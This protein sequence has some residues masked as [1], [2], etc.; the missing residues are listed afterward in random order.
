MRIG[1]KEAALIVYR[2]SYHILATW[3]HPG[4]EPG[5]TTPFTRMTHS[6]RTPASNMLCG[7]YVLDPLRSAYRYKTLNKV[8]ACE[9]EG[10]RGRRFREFTVLH[11]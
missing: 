4:V 10:Q 11:H 5:Q 9:A 2:L 1:A 3:M 7:N 6:K 8:P